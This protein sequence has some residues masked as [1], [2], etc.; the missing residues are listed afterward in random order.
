MVLT[1]SV[2][3]DPILEA[4]RRHDAITFLNRL[5]AVDAGDRRR[6][7]ADQPFMDEIRR[8]FRGSAL[9]SVRLILHFGNTQPENVRRLHMAVFMR[10]YRLVKDLI[11]TFPELRSE[12]QTPGAREMLNYELRG[13]PH[14][15]E[16]LRLMDRRRLAVLA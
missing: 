1:L 9:W 16:V 12:E 3:K 6:L 14:H 15:D 11:R 13:T 4:L 10:N 8:Y 7:E 5:R 2:I